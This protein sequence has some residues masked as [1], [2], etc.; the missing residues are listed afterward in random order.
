M[1][2]TSK[3]TQKDWNYQDMFFFLLQHCWHFGPDNSFVVGSVLYT[4]RLAS[5]Y[6]MPRVPP[7]QV[8][9]TKMHPKSAEY[10]LGREGVQN[11]L[12]VENHWPL[13]NHGSKSISLELSLQL[14]LRKMGEGSKF[15]KFT[16]QINGWRE[17]EKM[18]LQT[19]LGQLTIWARLCPSRK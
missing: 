6:N 3:S 10:P 14:S 16:Q 18:G 5:T 17:R 8:I 15:L 11:P 1:E 2:R 4:V 7:P 9:T 12:G 13:Q 19:L